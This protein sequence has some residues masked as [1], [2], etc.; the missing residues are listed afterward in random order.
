MRCRTQSSSCDQGARE[1]AATRSKPLST[2]CSLT[3]QFAAPGDDRLIENSIYQAA[4]C[5]QGIEQEGCSRTT[6]TATA[7]KSNR[8][9]LLLP[10]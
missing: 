9:V 2:V 7:S 6:N 1:R 4:G 10:S 8:Q 3:L 5:Q